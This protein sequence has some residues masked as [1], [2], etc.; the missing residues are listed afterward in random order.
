MDIIT[1]IDI[2]NKNI[3]Q[4]NH[5]PNI[6]IAMNFTNISLYG[7]A[8][9]TIYIVKNWNSSLIEFANYVQ[10]N[11]GNG[12]IA[13]INNNNIKYIYNSSLVDLFS[14]FGFGFDEINDINNINNFNIHKYIKKNLDNNIWNLWFP[15][16]HSHCIFNQC[17]Q[18]RNDGNFIMFACQISN[19]FYL[20]CFATS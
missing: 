14:N 4:D 9:L 8:D 12:W 10:S 15:R 17:I 11:K 3:L 18:I 7:D 13:N 6:N 20:L 19:T 1:W 16:S 2:R 5:N